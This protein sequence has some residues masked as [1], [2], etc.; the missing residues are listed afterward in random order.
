[1]QLSEKQKTFSQF[2][3]ALLKSI[4]NFERSEKQMT[5][6]GF[7]IPKLGTRKIWLD[8]C[9]KGSILQATW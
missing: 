1:M 9:R 2:F 5:L 8:R 7:V 4:S 6:I 3:A